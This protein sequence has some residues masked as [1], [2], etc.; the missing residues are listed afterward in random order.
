MI[1]YDP[2]ALELL[3]LDLPRYHK[4]LDRIMGQVIR[5]AAREWLRAVI[6]NVPVE[7]GMAKATLIPLGRFLRNVGGLGIN[8]S[9]KPYFSRLEGVTQEIDAGLVKQDFEIQDDKSSPLSFVY[10]FEW[11]T[12]VLHYWLAQYYKGNALPGEE[13]IEEGAIAFQ[14]HL[15]STIVNRLPHFAD[16]ILNKRI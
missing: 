2:Q 16:F 7:T 3:N 8:P 15:V 13:A 9:R 14:E 12:S 10:S 5:E 4:T 1:T 6:I 11:S